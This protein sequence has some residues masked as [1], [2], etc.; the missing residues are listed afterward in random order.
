MYSPIKYHHTEYFH[1]P[2]NSL[3]STYLSLS[4]SA[5]DEPLTNTCLSLYCFAFSSMFPPL[6]SG[7]IEVLPRL[8]SNRVALVPFPSRP[9]SA[10]PSC[11]HD[12]RPS[13]RSAPSRLQPPLTPQPDQ[14]PLPVDRRG[15]QVHFCFDTYLSCYVYSMPAACPVQKSRI[16]H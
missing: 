12:L 5:I 2:K 3:F 11:L 9:S 1:G 15:S 16:W 8:S 4:P 14:P 10:S 13:L 6:T 7:S